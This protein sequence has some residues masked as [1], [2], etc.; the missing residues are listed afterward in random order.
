MGDVNGMRLCIRSIRTPSA[1]PGKPGRSLNVRFHLL[2]PHPD[3]LSTPNNSHIASDVLEDKVG[4]L[5]LHLRHPS[6][7]R[8][9]Y[10]AAVGQ[11]VEGFV[12]RTGLCNEGIPWI[13]SLED[14]GELHS[15][16]QRRRYVLEGV[17]DAV[18]EAFVQGD[19]EI[20]GPQRFA[21]HEVEGL[22][23]VSVSRGRHGCEFK[24]VAFGAELCLELDQHRL[25]LD[26]GEDGGPRPDPDDL[27]VRILSC[28][29]RRQTLKS[30]HEGRVAAQRRDREDGGVGGIVGESWGRGGC[31]RRGCLCG[32]SGEVARRLRS[33]QHEG[34]G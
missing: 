27:V 1:S 7:A 10:A 31:R 11:V 5:P 12:G 23:R 21:S 32:V 3:S 17:D 24:R 33:G 18:D 25:C 20:L 4:I 9:P 19:L 14:G 30:L 28:L 29:E 15:L 6:H 26:E 16:R 22:G 34:K 8:A 2:F 13:L